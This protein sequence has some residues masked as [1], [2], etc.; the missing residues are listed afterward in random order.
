VRKL[1]VFRIRHHAML[2]LMLTAFAS[3]AIA[4][5]RPAPAFGRKLSYCSDQVQRAF[6]GQT[7]AGKQGKSKN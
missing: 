6:A 1:P 5:E 3:V 7:R 2:A 4:Q